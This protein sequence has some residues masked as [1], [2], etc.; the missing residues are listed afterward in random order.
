MAVIWTNMTSIIV[1][2][3]LPKFWANNIEVESQH[4]GCCL[5]S[6]C[7]RYEIWRYGLKPCFHPLYVFDTGTGG[8]VIWYAAKMKW[9]NVLTFIKDKALP[10]VPFDMGLD[11]LEY[12]VGILQIYQINEAT[13]FLFLLFLEWT[14]TIYHATGLGT[15]GKDKMLCCGNIIHRRYGCTVKYCGWHYAATNQKWA[16]GI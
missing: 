11:I 5:F 16:V 8:N 9:R 10:M 12:S 6:S 3:C 13:F 1:I 7:M 14:P 15:N 4:C 2:I